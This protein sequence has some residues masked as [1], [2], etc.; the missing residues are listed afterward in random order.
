MRKLTIL[1]MVVAMA[2]T[3]GCSKSSDNGENATLNN[4]DLVSQIFS[5][6]MGAYSSA[7]AL[8]GTYPIN[9]PAD[10]TQNGPEGGYIHVTG[11]V[12][13]SITVNDQ[14]GALISGIVQL[15]FTEVIN[16]YAFKSNGGIY[17][18]NGDPY[19]SL[20]GTFTLVPGGLFG[21]ASSMEI[22]GGVKVTGPN[23]NQTINIQLTIIINSNGQGG[24]VSGTIGGVGVDYDI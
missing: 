14:T 11:S 7:H 15:G 12:T 3:W 5:A 17:T 1:L 9:Y 21:S 10:Y 4:Q 23:F 6:S 2:A 13:G 16:G 20:A 24:H 22:G 19:I 8:K 18:M